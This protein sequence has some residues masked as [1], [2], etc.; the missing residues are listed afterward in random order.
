ML[1]DGNIDTG[2]EVNR[3]LN[4]VAGEWCLVRWMESKAVTRPEGLKKPKSRVHF[5]DHL[6][7]VKCTAS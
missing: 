1:D 3:Q 6:I 7:T 4:T 2:R 5:L